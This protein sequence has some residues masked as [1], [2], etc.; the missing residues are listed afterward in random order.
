MT[1][2]LTTEFK[3]MAEAM[4]GG[5]GPSRGSIIAQVLKS[6][7]DRSW[8]SDADAAIKAISIQM[9]TSEEHRSGKE[10][11]LDPGNLK[12]WKKIGVPGGPDQIRAIIAAQSQPRAPAIA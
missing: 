1:G 5:L 4:I 3:P 9:Q 10:I 8:N 7:A 6:V 11:I 2:K 12:D